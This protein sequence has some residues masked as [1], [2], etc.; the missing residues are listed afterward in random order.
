MDID[1]NR[2][3]LVNFMRG[4]NTL[5]DYAY[6]GSNMAVLL[7]LLAHDKFSI[8]WYV[9]MAIREG[10]PASAVLRNSIVS[11]AKSNN[12]LPQSMSSSVA[13]V[14]FLISSGDVKSSVTNLL[15]PKNTEFRTMVGN[16]GLLFT[17]GEDIIQPRSP[18]GDFIFTEIRLFEGTPVFERFVVKADPT[19]PTNRFAL[20]NETI[21]V[22]SLEVDVREETG[23]TFAL[24]WS[25]YLS[26][27]DMR[28]NARGYFVVLNREGKYEVQFGDGNVGRALSPGNVVETRYRATRG[29]GGNGA[30][31]FTLSVIPGDG[32]FLGDFAEEQVVVN[33]ISESSGGGDQEQ[34]ESIRSNTIQSQSTQ[35]RMVVEGDFRSLLKKRFGFLRDV[36]V[37]GGQ[38]AD[39]PR[40]GKIV[41]VLEHLNAATVSE[42]EK[43]AVVQYCE[44]KMSPVLTIAI[45]KP[46]YLFVDVAYKVDYIVGETQ[47]PES[48]RGRVSRLL[49]EYAKK[50]V[51]G[52]G[53]TFLLSQMT[54]HVVKSFS[55]IAGAQAE[56]LL[57]RRWE[58]LRV[59]QTFR[60]DNPIN[61]TDAASTVYSTPFR[62]QGQGRSVFADDGRGSMDI[63]FVDSTGTRRTLDKRVG[64]VD[65]SKGIVTL[66]HLSDI[67]ATQNDAILVYAKPAEDSISATQSR[68][69]TFNQSFVVPRPL[70]IRG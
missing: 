70:I 11:H 37:Y 18:N 21:D 3:D 38:K 48:L 51:N 1:S 68:L 17:T 29:S 58:D 55:E 19:V 10:H 65:Y 64:K 4:Q 45:D 30:R 28:E 15:L 49:G 67:A 54:T 24:P 35:N 42:N 44:T 69:L 25:R 61:S 63:V 39:P 43:K 9:N 62:Y 36:H 34:T 50:N 31:N 60:Y 59:G 8:L 23:A 41:L 52:F 56:I 16:D 5:K 20:S 32:S 22:D 14:S 26:A 57:F 66:N 7:D 2:E 33:T 46:E 40:F 6:D 27:A 13:V 47:N 53:R 12:Y